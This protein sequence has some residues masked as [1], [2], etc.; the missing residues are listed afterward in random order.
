MATLEPKL[1]RSSESQSLLISA[2]AWITGFQ[3]LLSAEW[4]G[5]RHPS[6]TW[7]ASCPPAQKRCEFLLLGEGKHLK[8]AWQQTCL[9]LWCCLLIL[10]IRHD[11]LCKG[12]KGVSAP[13]RLAL[14][15]APV[16][17]LQHRD[18]CHHCRRR[19]TF[20]EKACKDMQRHA[21]VDQI[22][23]N[24]I[25]N[26]CKPLTSVDHHGI[27]MHLILK[28]SD[29][30][31]SDWP[32]AAISRR[33]ITYPVGTYLPNPAHTLAPLYRTPLFTSRTLT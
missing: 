10:L 7:L 2:A 8:R 27:S 5:S 3:S 15:M 20:K 23:S 4:L 16:L 14:S 21:G 1:S 11:V 9:A 25:V 6:L 31:H 12:I 17:H 26:I 28:W 19:M 30:W 29:H 18:L 22:T 32:S 33:P 24:S 13:S